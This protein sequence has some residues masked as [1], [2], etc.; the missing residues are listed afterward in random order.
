MI[1]ASNLAAFANFGSSS[2]SAAGEDLDMEDDAVEVDKFANLRPLLKDVSLEIEQCCDEID[3]DVLRDPSAPMAPEDIEILKQG[4]AMF[5]PG[6]QQTLQSATGMTPQEA[7]DIGM[8]LE[9][10]GLTSDGDRV[11]GWLYRVAQH[12]LASKSDSMST[13]D[14]VASLA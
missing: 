1:D 2:T 9:D 14:P 7:A 12:G 3:P 5:D 11:S 8:Q 4:V 10:E 6:L 13:E